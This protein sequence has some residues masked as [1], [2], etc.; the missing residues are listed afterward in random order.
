LELQVILVSSPCFFRESA[1]LAYHGFAE[2]FQSFENEFVTRHY[3]SILKSPAI[4][5]LKE[6]RKNAHRII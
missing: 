6:C 5:I 1:S 3:N 4:I 2:M